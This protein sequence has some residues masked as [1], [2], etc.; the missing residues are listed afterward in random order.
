MT[1]LNY[2][3]VCNDM[4]FKKY[5]RKLKKKRNTKYNHI[6]NHTINICCSCT[7]LSTGSQSNLQRKDSQAEIIPLDNNKLFFVS[8]TRQLKQ[9]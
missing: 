5:H 2:N 4:I 1:Q 6:V 8:V 7:N 9:Q 3:H